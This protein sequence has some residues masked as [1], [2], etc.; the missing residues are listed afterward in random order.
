MVIIILK[1][2]LNILSHKIQN[3]DECVGSTESV[4]NVIPRA[5][6]GNT[7]TKIGK[8]QRRLMRPLYK[9]DTEIHERSLIFKWWKMEFNG[10]VVFKA[11]WGPGNT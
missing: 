5:R 10:G 2:K 1:L 11:T 8:I 4:K 3:C 6:F 7:Y 9:H